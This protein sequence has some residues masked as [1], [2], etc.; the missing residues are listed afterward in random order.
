MSFLVVQSSGRERE[1]WFLIFNCLLAV[2]A[3]VMC[4]LLHGALNWSAVC[5]CGVSWSNS[6]TFKNA[7]INLLL[8][9]P[10]EF[11]L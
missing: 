7:Y 9:C 6:L 3:S 5:D 1:S 4:I 11:P 10:I 8:I 2:D